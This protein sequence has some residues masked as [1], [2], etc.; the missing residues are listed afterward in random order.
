MTN[1]ISLI[2]LPSS[3]YVR[4][5]AADNAGREMHS[6]DCCEVSIC[7][8]GTGAG[9]DGGGIDGAVSDVGDG[10]PVGQD[11]V[12]LGL[13]GAFVEG[14]SSDDGVEMGEVVSRPYW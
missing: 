5:D 12:M 1:S 6:D 7:F 10:E 11:A 8:V 13:D 9:R 2:S 3:K 14:L 4:N